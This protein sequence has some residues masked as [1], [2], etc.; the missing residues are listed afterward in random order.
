MAGRRS[1]TRIKVQVLLDQG[2]NGADVAGVLGIST[3]DGRLPQAAAGD[4]GRRA[5]QAAI[6]LERDPGLLRPG[7][8][9]PSVCQQVR[10]R[11]SDVARGS[12]GGKVITRPQTKDVEHYLVPDGLKPNRGY[13]RRRLIEAGLKE[14]CCESCGLEDWRGG[15]ISLAL[16][17]VNGDSGTTTAWRTSRSCART[18]TRR[19]PTSASRTTA[20]FADG[21]GEVVPGTFPQRSPP[22]DYARPMRSHMLVTTVA[23]AALAIA[24]CGEDKEGSVNFEGSGTS[25]TGPPA[26]RRR[27][28]PRPPRQP[29]ARRWRRST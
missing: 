3:T 11:C 27:A 16:H 23:V 1:L 28:R 17:H 15:P 14:D 29:R 22:A 5:L 4:R 26:A 19:H 13:L 12:V 25:T 9:D 24:G 10:V 7:P 2:L 21:P 18:A 8:F 20:G 6:R